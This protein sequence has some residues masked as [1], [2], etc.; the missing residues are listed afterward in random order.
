[1]PKKKGG[2]KSPKKTPKNALPSSA[3]AAADGSGWGQWTALIEAEDEAARKAS[4]LA[5]VKRT[6]RECQAR[7]MRLREAIRSEQSAHEAETMVLLEEATVREEE[8]EGRLAAIKIEIQ[9]LSDADE[10][11]KIISRGNDAIGDAALKSIDRVFAMEEELRKESDR[12][13]QDKSHHVSL[14]NGEIRKT[15]TGLKEELEILRDPEK[16][17]RTAELGMKMLNPSEMIA[18]PAKIIDQTR[19]RGGSFRTMAERNVEWELLEDLGNSIAAGSRGGTEKSVEWVVTKLEETNESARQLELQ[20][21]L[22]DESIATQYKKLEVLQASMEETRARSLLLRDHFSRELL[23][24]GTTMFA[25]AS[26]KAPR[27]ADQKAPKGGEEE[28]YTM[29]PSWKPPAEVAT[30]N[31]GKGDGG[32]T[33]SR[34]AGGAVGVSSGM[35]SDGAVRSSGPESPKP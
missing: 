23:H 31:H 16:H 1:M 21:L 6:I 7:E 12:L 22:A 4:E 17:A 25:S 29:H 5:Q 33:T 9:G 8:L 27:P 11:N 32:K 13:C 24:P 28:Y 10:A 35:Q 3:E 34:G 14:I 20:I 18:V 19:D 30:A 26:K 15:V 2:S